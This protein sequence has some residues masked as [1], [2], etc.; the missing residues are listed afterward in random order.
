[1]FDTTVEEMGKIFVTTELGGGG[2]VTAKSAGIAKSGVL[3]LLHHAGI[4][5]EAPQPSYTRWLDM[6]SEACFV[7]AEEDGLLEFLKDP[8]EAVQHGEEI[9]R[10]H[11]IGRTGA[12]PLPYTAAI[13]GLLAARHFPGLVKTGDCLAVVAVET[14]QPL[15]KKAKL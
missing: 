4:L 8:G 11:P 3:N 10:I 9:A 12:A 6:P 15:D 5:R 7:F 1:M 2:T 14:T 13:D